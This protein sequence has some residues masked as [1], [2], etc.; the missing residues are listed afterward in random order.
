M[1][2]WILPLSS[3]LGFALLGVP[4]SSHAPATLSPAEQEVWQMELKLVEF[5]N[6]GNIE[7]FLGLFHDDHVGWSRNDPKAG[8]KRGPAKD[9]FRASP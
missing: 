2:S 3:I 8:H 6:A 9:S 1:R 5:S 7:G 4:R